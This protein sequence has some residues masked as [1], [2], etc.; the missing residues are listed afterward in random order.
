MLFDL[1]SSQDIKVSMNLPNLYLFSR[2]CPLP[3]LSSQL[4]Y[5]AH[6]HKRT[7]YSLVQKIVVVSFRNG[8]EG[9]SCRG[10]R[11]WYL[12]EAGSRAEVSST[13]DRRQGRRS[14][15]ECRRSKVEGQSQSQRVKVRGSKSEGQ[16]Q[17]VKVSRSKS[18]GPS[19]RV[20]VKWLKLIAEAYLK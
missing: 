15:V 6:C 14:K 17:R 9:V 2:F 11:R 13:S 20:E 5:H 10:R 18:V 12:P 3:Y 8:W 7:Q 16:C 19:Q 4:D 1:I